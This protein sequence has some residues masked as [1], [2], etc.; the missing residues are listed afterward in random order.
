[1]ITASHP[2]TP[3]RHAGFTIAE[4]LVVVAIILVVL[5][6]VIVATRAVR[7]AGGRAGSSAFL[8][9]LATAHSTYASDHRQQMIPGH[10]TPQLQEELGISVVGPN[11][12]PVP[13][14]AAA[15]WVWRLVPY[16]GDQ[17]A[18]LL[19]DVGAASASATAS[20]EISAGDLEQLA[21]H[22]NF[23]MNTIFIGGD[24]QAGGVA[25]RSPWNTAG[26]APIAA[27]RLSEV[28]QPAKT[29]LFA[30]TRFRDGSPLDATSD[31]GYYEL[32]APVL[33][34]EQWT[35]AQG[36]ATPGAGFVQ[37]AGLPTIRS[38]G[39]SL[40]IVHVDGSV[41]LTTLLELHRDMRRWSPFA[42][43][44]NWSVGD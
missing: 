32:R 35:T 16:L 18:P 37:P 28:R 19:S 14:V 11:G 5:S 4:M 29:V 22:P 40:P 15:T 36:V 17:W 39:D 24:S 10:L 34:A 2:R 31:R 8:R 6:I 38:G 41:Q 44:E 23:G 25:N 13:D 43:S 1:M 42:D 26:N 33:V 27:T 12:A 3:R 9:Q 21:L 7:Q 20:A 30:P